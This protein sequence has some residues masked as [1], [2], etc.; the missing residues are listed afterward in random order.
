[1]E[2]ELRSCNGPVRL[3]HITSEDR[4]DSILKY[5]LLPSRYGDMSVGENDGAGIY[6]IRP[7]KDQITSVMDDLFFY[8]H[9]LFGVC[10]DYYGTYYECTNVVFTEEDY[11]EYGAPHQNGYIVI[12]AIDTNPNPSIAPKDFVSVAP[13]QV[14]LRANNYPSLDT[15]LEQAA[16]RAHQTTHRPKHHA[17]ETDHRYPQGGDISHDT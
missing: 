16:L 6:A 7:L 10:F 3:L 13:I 4:I 1:M 11:E 2:L 14:F 17:A 8:G 9:D 5:G 12:P 15:R